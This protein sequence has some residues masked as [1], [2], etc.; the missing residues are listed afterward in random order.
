MSWRRQTFGP[1]SLAVPPGLFADEEAPPGC[2]AA[3]TAIAP[4]TLRLRIIQPG[5]ARSLEAVMA[6][7][8]S[9]TAAAVESA[10]KG[11]VWPGL[12]AQEDTEPQRVHFLFETGGQVFHGL[13]EAPGHLWQDYGT[14]L[15][16]VMCSLDPGEAPRPTLPLFRTA[17]VPQSR[18]REPPP[19][20]VEQ[21]RLRLD[22]VSGEVRGLILDGRFAEAEARLR[23]IDGDIQGAVA[24]AAA[25]ETALAAAPTSAAILERAV[26]W[27]RSAFPDAHT[28]VEAGAYRAA[29]EEAEAR[30]K[31][32]F[33][34]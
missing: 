12:R 20:P 3:L 29:A 19:D 26:Y 10:G 32:I 11:Y 34:P 16:A 24:L 27:A 6:G 23:A 13:A 5:G 15:E 22:E 17:P 21:V 31:A 30:L 9:A 25:Y 4:A 14:F 8:T 7:L 33:T 28:A 18:R 2:L 1:I